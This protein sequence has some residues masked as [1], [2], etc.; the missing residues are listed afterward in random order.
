ME[1]LVRTELTSPLP[2]DSIEREAL[3]ARERAVGVELKRRGI[4]SHIW[5][6]PGRQANIAV[7]DVADAT[8][9]H[10]VLT[11]LPLW[12]YTTV[13]VEPLAV[14]PLTAS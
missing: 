10:D 14:H 9:L 11:S 4:I 7:M 2:E 1:F 6:V 3:L 13:T 12:P 5:R 8:E